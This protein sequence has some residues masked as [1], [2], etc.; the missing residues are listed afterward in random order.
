MSPGTDRSG[1]ERLQKL[2]ANAGHGSRREI[3]GWIREGRV[4]VDGQVVGLGDR[5]S[6]GD[7]IRLDGEPLPVD[8]TPRRPRALMYHKP[9]GELVTRDDP[10]DR[11]TVFEKLPRHNRGR[12]IA[13]GRLDINSC[14]LILF[15]DDGDMADRLMHPSYEI[16]RAYAVRVDAELTPEAIEA[17]TQGVQL[18]DGPAS[19]GSVV[20]GGG[21]GRNRWYHVTLKEGRKREVRRVFET[22][23]A[24]VNRLIRTAYG[25]VKLPRSLRPGEFRF[26]DDTMLDTLRGAVGL[27]ALPQRRQQPRDGKRRSRGPRRGPRRPKRG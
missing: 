4:T 13:V 1:G 25:P 20:P 15:T 7:D 17:L 24:K 14:G 12:W 18:D 3:E 26:L 9:E 11:P 2:L 21:Q 10:E 5:A 27:E 16:E 6:A 23:G 8:S 19:L 22:Q